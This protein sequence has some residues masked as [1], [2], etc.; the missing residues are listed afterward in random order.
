[1][2]RVGRDV[3]AVTR[4]E[5]EGPRWR[6]LG[7]PLPG[8]AEIVEY[9]HV[10]ATT[11]AEWRRPASGCAGALVYTMRDLRP[12]AGW[13]VVDALGRP[14]SSWFALRRVQ[15]PRAIL[16]SD[17]G[18]NGL[19]LHVLNDCAD[20]LMGRVRVELF[21]RGEMPLEQVEI[22]VRVDGRGSVEL[23]HLFDGFRD[24]TYAYRFGSPA[25][26]VVVASLVDDRDALVS[27][28]VYLPLG[29][30]RALEAD[31]GLHATAKPLD[32]GDWL[33]VVETRRFAQSVAVDVP[34]FRPDDSWFDLP[35]GAIASIVLH[36]VSERTRPSGEVRALNSTVTASISVES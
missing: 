30:A 24:L 36:P 33:L 25:H 11:M 15:Q 13:G 18:L 3:D 1:M 17:E 12:G 22:D 21:A 23:S 20:A 29:L 9:P 4:F 7:H 8:V 32:G 6:K 31:I 5:D 34:G 2:E 16:A 14:K 27:R 19:R 10:M 35:P 28:A 26:D